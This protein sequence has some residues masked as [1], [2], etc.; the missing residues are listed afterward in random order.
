MEQLDILNRPISSLAL[1][2]GFISAS[3]Y[4]NFVTLGDIL[5][6]PPAALLEKEGFNYN[7]LGELVKFLNSQKLLHLL[8]PLPGSSRD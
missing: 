3:S 2:E 7:W 5:A 4:M 8:Q 6:T 1:S